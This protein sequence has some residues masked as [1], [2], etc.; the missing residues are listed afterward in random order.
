MLAAAATA[1]ALRDFFPP[2]R[3]GVDLTAATEGSA[4]RVGSAGGS[5]Q[6]GAVHRKLLGAEAG[7]TDDQADK[8]DGI[9]PVEIVL[10]GGAAKAAA[11]LDMSAASLAAAATQRQS[12]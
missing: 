6:L 10:S 11:A 8:R 12:L 9:V 1:A 5:S 4:A 3:R 7:R 2:T